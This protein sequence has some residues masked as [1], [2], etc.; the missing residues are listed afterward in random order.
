MADIPDITLTVNHPN[1]LPDNLFQFYDGLTR[2]ERVVSMHPFCDG[3]VQV[4]TEDEDSGLFRKE[5]IPEGGKMYLSYENHSPLF[6]EFPGK[7]V[8][9]APCGFWSNEIISDVAGHWE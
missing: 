3:I 8:V 9:I 6:V 7:L 2:K 5:L 4:V 1:E